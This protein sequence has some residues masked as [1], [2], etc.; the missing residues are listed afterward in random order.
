MPWGAVASLAGGLIAGKGAR[1]AGKRAASG[2]RDAIAEQRRQFDITQEQNKP[3]LEAGQRGL[4]RYEDLLGRQSEFESQI[5]SNIPAQFQSGKNIPEAYQSSTNIPGAFSRGAGDYFG[6]IQSNVQPGFQ[7]GREEFNQYKDPGY[8]FRRE[9]GLRALERRNAKGGQRNS[10]YNT[11]SLMELGQ[12]L[13]SQEFGRARERAFGDYQSGVDREQQSYGRGV[14]DYGRRI[15]REAELYGRGRQ[16]RVDEI[17]L[18]Q[19]GYQRGRQGVQDRT[20]RE[21]EQ[22]GRN[23]RD[24]GLGV[25][26]EQAVY[27]RGLAQYGRQYTDQLNREAGLSGVG[28]QTAAN[29][30]QQ[31]GAFSQNIGNMIGQAGA[32]EAAGMA[33]QAGAYAGALG[34]AGEQ[35]SQ[36]NLSKFGDTSRQYGG[37]SR[38][39]WGRVI[40]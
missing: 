28:Q 14:N 36:R 19:A 30:G 21:Q 12:N 6:N 18:E 24:Y 26:R 15:G 37:E 25:E 34:A 3:W 38:D 23:L 32:Y 16:Q 9:E 20:A 5:Q 1:D 29:L 22:Y 8:D 11:R 39:S 10:G 7:F 2:Q 40:Y 27:G 33:G 35:F 31:R 13:G 4:G 17:G